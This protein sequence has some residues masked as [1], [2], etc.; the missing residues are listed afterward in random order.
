M[1]FTPI[2]QVI[3]PRE[4]PGCT[5]GRRIKSWW[6]AALPLVVCLSIVLIPHPAGLELY[7]W[8]YF[9]LFAAVVVALIV[10]P[11]P[12]AAVG[13]VG[14]TVAAV[15]RYVVSSPADSIKW[16]LGGFSD[17]T[18]WLIFG[19]FMFALGNEKTGLGKRIALM[20][21]KSLGRRALGLGYAITLSD[22]V[23][24]PFIP[25]NTARSGGTIFPIISNIPALYGSQPGKT[26][27]RIGSYIMWTAFAATCVTSSMFLTALAPNI[28]ALTLIKDT[29]KIS[30]T[31][32]A[33]GFLPA[34]VI[35]I[36]LLPI[37]IYKIYPPEV[38]SNEEIP[39]W[40][41][42][43]LAG[44]GKFTMK[45]LM[46]ALLVLTALALWIFGGQILNATTVTLIVISLMIIS[47]IVKWDEILAYKQAWSVLVWFATL[48]T[49]ADGLNKVGFINWFAKGAANLLSGIRPLAIMVI[50]VA[51][52]YIVHYLF[53]S[54]TAHTTAVLPIILAAGAAVPGLPV[55]TF[56]LLLCYSMGLM[57]VLTPYAT[58]PAPVYFGSGYI[59][60]KD[61][62]TLGLIF[63]MIF[64][65]VLLVIGVPYLVF[66]NP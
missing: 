9:A 62:W 36:L 24:A 54:L 65:A 29:V 56:A 20:L 34:G 53:A 52:H 14:V 44:M 18:V 47:G 46:M 59:S 49:L 25:S 27:R 28:L 64:L 26:A 57:G 8:R 4:V 30:W 15:S 63:G 19:A 40:A 60:R 43:E 51:L 45:E 50:L 41:S 16:A 31:Q 10:E 33:I 21:V 39:R 1:N 35:L 17:S 6:R 23:L 32:W 2:P 5:Q 7:A 22:L 66:I 13:L 61:F 42:Q 37:L 58:G 38:T 11:I 48:V 3:T 12:A 55:R